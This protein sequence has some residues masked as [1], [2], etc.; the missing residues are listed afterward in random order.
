MINIGDIVTRNKYNNDTVFKVIDIKDNVY[1]LKGINVRLCA[2]S[3]LS[4]LKKEEEYRDEKEDDS[5]ILEMLNLPK[6]EYR[7]EYFYIPGKI[8]HID[9]DKD[10]LQRCLKFYK[11]A[12]INAYGVYDKEENL[13]FNIRK[14][15]E[16]TIWRAY[17]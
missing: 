11:D 17:L 2:D 5:K 16:G 15:L 10:Y 12:N 4:D 13:C 8:L 3:E 6:N 7:S 1:F 14:Y 9:A